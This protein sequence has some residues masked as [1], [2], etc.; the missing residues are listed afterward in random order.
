[1]TLLSASASLVLVF[2]QQWAMS[3][4]VL[5]TFFILFV[6]FLKTTEKFSGFAFTFVIFAAVSASL[7]YPTVFTGFGDFYYK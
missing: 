2:M 4:P 6:S 7:Y 5:I 3:G 1:M